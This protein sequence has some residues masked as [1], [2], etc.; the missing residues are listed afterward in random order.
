MNIAEETAVSS[1]RLLTLEA[2]S[3]QATMAAAQALLIVGKERG[4]SDAASALLQRGMDLFVL[5]FHEAQAMRSSCW[6]VVAAAQALAAALQSQVAVTQ[7]DLAAL[8]AAAERAAA[9]VKK[10]HR[11]RPQ[12]WAAVVDEGAAM[13][14]AALP[15]ARARLQL[16]NS[17]AVDS[18]A[19]RDA[20]AAAAAGRDSALFC[21]G[22]GKR[23]MG[24]RRCGCCKQAA[25]EW[26]GGAAW[27]WQR[28]CT[29]VLFCAR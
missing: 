23:A 11:L 13:A 1:E 16:G 9:A 12:S 25:C 20:F 24:L 18:R 19:A 22:C 29:V 4:G 15:A 28:C 27:R 26:A 7:P 17:S 10:L 21:A 8:I 6:A 3:P 14:A 2:G 5:A